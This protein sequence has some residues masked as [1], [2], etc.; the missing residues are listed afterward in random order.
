MYHGEC[1]CKKASVRKCVYFQ[2]TVIAAIQV[3]VSY[4]QSLKI[5]AAEIKTEL[6]LCK[7]H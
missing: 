6:I 3:F 1:L 7:L 4:H 5:K 2:T